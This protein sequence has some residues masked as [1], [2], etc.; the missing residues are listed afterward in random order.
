MS[1]F[2]AVFI[3]S[4]VHIPGDERSRT[5]P[6]HGYPAYDHTYTE[7]VEFRTMQELKEWIVR[8]N[9]RQEFRAVRCSPLTVSLKPVV[10]EVSGATQ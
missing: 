4:S 3:K 6:G 5:N 7:I 8:N 10:V 2:Y 9:G 1:D